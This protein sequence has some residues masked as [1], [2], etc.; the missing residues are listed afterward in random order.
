MANSE[1]FKDE[2]DDDFEIDSDEIQSYLNSFKHLSNST[3]DKIFSQINQA[4]V[5]AFNKGYIL[6]NP[7]VNVIKPRSLK[8][9]KEVRALTFEEQQIFTDYLLERGINQCRYKNVFLIQMY[10]GLRI[11]ETLALTVHDINLKRKKMN[12][13]RTLTVDEN[14]M[15]MMGTTTKTYAGKR[16]L[17]IPD[18]MMPHIMEQMKIANDQDN[19]PEK[20]LFKPIDKQYAHRGNVNNEL[21]RLLQRHFGIND[22]TTHCLRH[23]YGTRCIEAGMAPVVVQKLMG[24][25]DVGVTLNTYTSVFDRF[26]EK[27][28]DKMNKYFLE[29]NMLSSK[30]MLNEYEEL[31]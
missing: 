3:I 17:P 10:M 8:K 4:F 7:M 28:I 14:G 24:H 30:H 12:I 2:L 15:V 6:K 21:K 29:E 11:G 9:N 22:I 27:E 20:L 5:S 31:E 26:K 13:Y 18:F 16:L 23:T 19:N 1:E 25:T